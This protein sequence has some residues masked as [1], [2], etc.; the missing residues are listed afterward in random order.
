MVGSTCA[1]PAPTIFS[2]GPTNNGWRIAPASKDETM[3]LDEQATM[4]RE[5][6]AKFVSRELILLEPEVLRRQARG[7]AG[8]SGEQIQRLRD[9]SKELGLWGLD[10]PKEMGGMDLPATT[11]LGVAEELAKTIVPF[12]LPPD[13]PN[14]RMMQAVAS[15]AQQAKYLQPYIEGTSTSATAI[16]EPGPGGAPPAMKP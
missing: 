13:S 7:E 8:L 1:H 3:A 9:V 2:A 4:V 14:L 16:S 12:S 15:P 5:L 10:A 6:V 11:M